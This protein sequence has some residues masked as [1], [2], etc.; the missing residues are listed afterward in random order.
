MALKFINGSLKELGALANTANDANTTFADNLRSVPRNLRVSA[1]PE[2]APAFVT[3]AASFGP[4][5]TFM[6][7]CRVLVRRYDTDATGEAT[8]LTLQ[9]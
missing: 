4:A 6:L 7:S 5:A 8:A 9:A 1:P 2:C 3:A